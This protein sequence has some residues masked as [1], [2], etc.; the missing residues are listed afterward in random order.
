MQPVEAILCSEG[1]GE[2]RKGY[3][4]IYYQVSAMD[5]KEE[6]V[7]AALSTI[8]DTNRHVAEEKFALH[9]FCLAPNHPMTVTFW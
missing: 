5:K 4:L 2:K 1:R 6:S 3:N 8:T 9:H 7:Q